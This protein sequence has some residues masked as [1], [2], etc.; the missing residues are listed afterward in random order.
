ML[1]QITVIDL[2]NVLT[3]PTVTGVCFQGGGA[4]AGVR[5][6]WHADH[7]AA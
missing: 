2:T 4:S 1:M 6:H 5:R 7:G 3:W